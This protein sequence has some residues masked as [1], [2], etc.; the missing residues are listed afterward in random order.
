VI[1]KKIVFLKKIF[2]LFFISFKAYAF[3]RHSLINLAQETIKIYEKESIYSE[4]EDKTKK[5]KDNLLKIKILTQKEIKNGNP[6]APIDIYLFLNGIINDDSYSLQSLLALSSEY[7]LP[8]DLSQIISY[9]IAKKLA[10]AMKENRISQKT[11]IIIKSS[12]F[13]KDCQVYFNGF[14]IKN[15]KSFTSPAGVPFYLGIYCQDKTFEIQKVHPKESQQKMN[16]FFK[17]LKIIKGLDATNSLSSKMSPKDI[18]Q[19]TTSQQTSAI[20]NTK[21]FKNLLQIT[22]GIGFAKTNIAVTS[23]QAKYRFF[24]KIHTN[25][26]FFST[27]SLRYQYFLF[28]FDFT[29]LLHK[30]TLYNILMKEL[31]TL[32]LRYALGLGLPIIVLSKNI[33]IEAAL[34]GTFSQLIGHNYDYY[35]N[36]FGI[37]ASLGPRFHITN[38]FFVDTLLKTSYTKPAIQHGLQFEAVAQIGYNF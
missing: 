9:S 13:K 12:S 3:D 2:Y 10:F 15:R 22:T 26:F 20:F 8:K 38:H 28:S 5:L 33:H 21:N 37:Q 16:V 29:E 27:S 34:Q 7:E 14:L 19:P 6:Q 4:E 11:K 30:V 1:F 18:N 31:N 23:N 17:D 24:K 36:G 32:Y 25:P 35:R